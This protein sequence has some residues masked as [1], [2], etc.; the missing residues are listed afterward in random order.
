M[1]QNDYYC[2]LLYY[3][4]N[5]VEEEHLCRGGEELH[6]LLQSVVLY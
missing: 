4:C 5:V 2:L 1:K 3:Y 6:L